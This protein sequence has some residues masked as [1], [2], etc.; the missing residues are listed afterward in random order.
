MRLFGFL[1][2]IFLSS[3]YILH[4]GPLSD[5]GLVKILSQKAVLQSNYDKKQRNKQK[6]KNNNNKKSAWYWYSD[7]QLDQ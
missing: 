4:I 6:Q 5:L 1:K 3:L 2:S 7:R